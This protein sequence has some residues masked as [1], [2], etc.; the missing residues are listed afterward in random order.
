MS[1]TTNKETP[2]DRTS[3]STQ[4]LIDALG[5]VVANSAA[6]FTHEEAGSR[7]CPFTSG[8]VAMCGGKRC[9]YFHP[10]PIPDKYADG[11]PCATSGEMS[12]MPP[13]ERAKYEESHRWAF[14]EMGVCAKQDMKPPQKR[15]IFHCDEEWIKGSID[16]LKSRVAN[17][18]SPDL[19]TSAKVYALI[20]VAFEATRED[21]HDFLREVFNECALRY[22]GTA[23][24][25]ANPQP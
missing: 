9:G 25:R 10:A 23:I 19:M 15:P 17:A 13:E 14:G 4:Q 11:F 22:S 16:V 21:E 18:I 3:D 2:F 8:Q 1:N 12:R 7:Q 20:E 24:V 6:P 5:D